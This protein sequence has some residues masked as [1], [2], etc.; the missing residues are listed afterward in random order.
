[1]GFIRFL[2]A[3]DLCKIQ[4]YVILGEFTNKRMSAI[5]A[6]KN[7]I[8]YFVMIFA[9]TNSS[10]WLQKLCRKYLLIFANF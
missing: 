1:M 3:K 5:S 8:C 7:Y 2:K 4:Q 6:E 10:K 9:K